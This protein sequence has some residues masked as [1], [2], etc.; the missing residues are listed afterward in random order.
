MANGRV[1]A[2]A[3][4]GEHAVLGAGLAARNRRVD[5]V[6]AALLRFGMK[7]ARDLGR[8]RGVVDHDRALAR[9]GEDAVLAEHHFAQIVVVADAGHD[10]I[11]ALGRLFRGRRAF[12]AVLRDPFFGLGGG[13]VVDRDLV[14][15]F[16]LEMP[17]HRVAHHAEP[18]ECD[19]CHRFLHDF[20]DRSWPGRRR[21][22]TGHGDCRD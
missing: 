21:P 16:G 19:L 13:A 18:D 11:L 6:E 7:L 22:S 20:A 8:G 14:A 10:E 4:H 9:A 12:A 2:A 3:H 1:V 15:A 5:E 17:R